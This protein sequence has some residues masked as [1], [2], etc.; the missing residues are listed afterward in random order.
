[1][2]TA[3][4]QK[5]MGAERHTITYSTT[6]GALSGGIVAVVYMSTAEKADVLRELDMF[7]A[8]INM[9]SA[10]AATDATWLRPAASI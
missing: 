3:L 1:M 4:L 10:K 8:E 9:R 6:A 7:R 5:A 2:S